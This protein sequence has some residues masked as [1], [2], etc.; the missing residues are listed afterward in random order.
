VLPADGID[1]FCRVISRPRG[2]FRPASDQADP[3]PE[4]RAGVCVVAGV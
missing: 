3:D 2:G 4:S 1:G